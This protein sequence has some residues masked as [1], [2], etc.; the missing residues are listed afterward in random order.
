MKIG[1]TEARGK[2]EYC[3]GFLSDTVK[4][5]FVCN[6]KKSQKMCLRVGTAPYRP[7]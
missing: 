4:C 2:G 1:R 5:H 6:F 3:G 7:V